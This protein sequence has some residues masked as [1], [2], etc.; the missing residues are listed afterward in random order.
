MGSLVLE[1][2]LELDPPPKGSLVQLDRL[3]V[4][5]GNGGSSTGSG[6]PWSSSSR[7][8]SAR[9]TP[10]RPAS[11]MSLAAAFEHDRERAEYGDSTGLSSPRSPG[12]E[13][14]WRDQGDAELQL[15]RDGM[16]RSAKLVTQLQG[17]DRGGAATSPTAATSAT[18]EPPSA[19]SAVDIE[20]RLHQHLQ[21]LAE[22]ERARDEQ[23]R[24]AA[25]LVREI[26]SLRGDGLDDSVDW[27]WVS[28]LNVPVKA[29]ATLGW[30]GDA[31]RSASPS[32]DDESEE[33]EEDDEDAHT[34]PRARRRR[35]TAL[36]GRNASPTSPSPSP[37]APATP[38]SPHSPLSP[39]SPL[40]PTAPAGRFTASQARSTS[41]FT[42]P[43]P[44][45]T[46]DLA[47]GTALAAATLSQ[48]GESVSLA[49]ALTSGAARSVRG[50]RAAATAARER[51]EHEDACR[52]GVEGWEARVVA[53]D[54]PDARSEC[55]ALVEGFQRSLEV[56]EAQ[57]TELRSRGRA[58]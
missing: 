22:S 57:M 48:L 23:S 47:H 49:L 10:R 27:S 35:Q 31:P 4:N 14:G 15:L 19:S 41:T 39:M 38:T 45:S 7:T 16:A 29:V 26:E 3:A 21:R 43:L 55:A 2:E 5:T 40:T 1:L 37:L 50:V 52:R 42:A 28:V 51:D 58:L 32:D 34:T 30:T 24:E 36:Q 44:R 8:R 12:D 13:D 20:D 6:T 54:V 17:L 56:Y 33:E 18:T 25:A 53:G 46:R 9:S 11:R